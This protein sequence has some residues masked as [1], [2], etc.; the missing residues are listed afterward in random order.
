MMLQQTI[1]QIEAQE[2]D[3]PALERLLQT[4][5]TKVNQRMQIG[6]VIQR[7]QDPPLF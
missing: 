4:T 5:R 2:L 6:I 1:L 3:V 7:A